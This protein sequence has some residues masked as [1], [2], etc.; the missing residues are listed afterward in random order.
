MVC[1][2][3]RRAAIVALV[4]MVCLVLRRAAIV[5]IIALTQLSSRFAVQHCEII[6]CSIGSLKGNISKIQ[7]K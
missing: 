5:T 4:D 6:V 2:V 1:L 3:L 7:G